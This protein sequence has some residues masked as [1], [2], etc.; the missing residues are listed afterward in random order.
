[1]IDTYVTCVTGVGVTLETKSTHDNYKTDLMNIENSR[2]HANNGD[3]QA[4]V[5]NTGLQ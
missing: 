2:H 5:H 1:M 4:A 3:D